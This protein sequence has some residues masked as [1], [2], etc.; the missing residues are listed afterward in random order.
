MLLV[1]FLRLGRLGV[2]GS[3]RRLQLRLGIGDLLL[4]LL[5]D[6]GL[7]L[8]DLG[9]LLRELGVAL[10]LCFLGRT[11][12][13]RLA[14][15][16]VG[17]TLAVLG[18]LLRLLLLEPFRRLGLLLERLLVLGRQGP[19]RRR[20]GGHRPDRQRVAVHD[21][22]RRRCQRLDRRRR[23][24]RVPGLS[25]G[26]DDRCGRWHGGGGHGLWHVA[27]TRL[28]GGRSAGPGEGRRGGLERPLLFQRGQVRFLEAR[29]DWRHALR[30]VRQDHRRDHDHELGPILLR[31]LAL[32]EQPENRDVAN[33]RDL[34]ERLVHLVADQPGDREGLVVLQLQ[35][36]FGAARRERRNLEA[37]QQD[38]VA[39]VE[40]ADF[41]PDLEVHAV[42]VDDR[43]EVQADAEFLEHHS[44]GDG[45][46]GAWLRDGDWDLA[47]GEEAGLFPALGYQ[48]RLGETLE[49]P[50]L[51]Q[52]LHERPDIVLGIEEEEVQEIA[53]DQLAVLIPLRRW[54]LLGRGPADPPAVVVAVRDERR[55]QLGEDGPTDFREADLEHHLVARRPLLQR[56]QRDDFFLLVDEPGRQVDGLVD[57]VLIADRSRENDVLPVAADF[58]LL[59]GEQLLDLLGQSGQIALD[60]H[61]VA[62][63]AA[64]AIPDEHRDRAR[65]LAV[66]QQFG[67]R[68]D[69][70]VGDVRHR[71][72]HAG[73]RR[74]DTDDRRSAD[75]QAD[76]VVRADD[77][78]VRDDDEQDENERKA[79]NPA[80]GY[81]SW[82]T[83]SCARLSPRMISTT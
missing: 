17:L 8:V 22:A 56:Q 55:A 34:R 74:S 29:D 50:T 69:Q 10:R 18:V 76:A 62:L 48:V 12:D 43:R 53:E 61:L 59:P 64:G 27:R 75:H 60:D 72:R 5:V 36:G 54:K 40:R 65:H 77:L 6:L 47:T 68:R 37:I 33:A 80:H 42:A 71:Q 35:L 11:I 15:G 7:F 46:A 26:H 78:V 51:L 41:R 20:R 38:G 1:L 45:A 21:L 49:Q 39:E 82:R 23:S 83:I 2:I 14:F 30:I 19:R 9:L 73:D 79:T 52:R 25:R 4:V 28:D 70:G 63:D 24:R 3:L 81:C 58:D 57:D 32:E 67:R 31:G 44:D 13:R 66:D 16:G